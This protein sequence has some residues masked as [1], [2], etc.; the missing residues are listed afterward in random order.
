M[1]EAT[2]LLA[3]KETIALPRKITANTLRVVGRIGQVAPMVLVGLVALTAWATAERDQAFQ[4]EYQTWTD[5]L[6]YEKQYAAP[7]GQI[8]AQKEAAIQDPVCRQAVADALQVINASSQPEQTTPSELKKVEDNSA[9]AQDGQEAVAEA[10]M[11]GKTYTDAQND[12]TAT[13]Q[14]IYTMDHT[15]Y[16]HVIVGPD[17]PGAVEA[18]TGI[19]IGGLIF[20]GLARFAAKKIDHNEHPVL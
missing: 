11:S 17:V 5:H 12:V 7:I 6:G 14:D 20:N 2:S 1:T 19:I 9:C 15:N 18:G 8:A 3:T 4:Q 10:I 13:S 16:L